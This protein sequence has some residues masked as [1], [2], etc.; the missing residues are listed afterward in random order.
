MLCDNEEDIV[1]I[2]FGISSV[3]GGANTVIV[4]KTGMTPEYSA[5]ETFR[6]LFLEESDY[7]SLGTSRAVSSYLFVEQTNR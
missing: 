7:Y 6:N 5:S 3:K 4:T 1:I 2:D